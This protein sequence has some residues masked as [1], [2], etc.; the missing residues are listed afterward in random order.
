M[1]HVTTPASAVLA[2]VLLLAAALFG[3]GLLGRPAVSY[4]ESQAAAPGWEYRTTTVNM[5]DYAETLNKLGAD[6]W[7]VFAVDRYESQLVQEADTNYLRATQ[8]M[9]TARRPTR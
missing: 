7:E 4:G 5:F 2:S 1:R 8:L 3:V 6:G 9:I